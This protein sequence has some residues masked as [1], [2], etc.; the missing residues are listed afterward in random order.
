[1]A[2]GL[3]IGGF[4]YIGFPQYW[5][6]GMLLLGFTAA[7]AVICGRV[8]ARQLIW[9]LAASLLGLALLLPVLIGSA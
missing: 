5:F 7:V 2:A 1:M 3:A 4:Y 8:A 6:Y 9:P